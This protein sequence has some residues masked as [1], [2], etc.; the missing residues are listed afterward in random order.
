MPQQVEEL[1]IAASISAPG[2]VALVEKQWEARIVLTII[3]RITEKAPGNPVPVEA[4]VPGHTNHLLAH[5]H[6]RRTLAPANPP[7]I[8][9]IMI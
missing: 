6:G 4:I 7:S 2:V 3:I 1:S 5:P 8:R 9:M